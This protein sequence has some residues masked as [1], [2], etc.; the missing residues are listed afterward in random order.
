MEYYS[1]VKNE[2]ILPITMTWMDHED[3][4]LIEISQAEE[5][6]YYMIS[7]MYRI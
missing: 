5:D 7:L 1:A 4:M 6:K 3:I 2:E